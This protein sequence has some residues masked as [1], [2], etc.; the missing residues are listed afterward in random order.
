MVLTVV[1]GFLIYLEGNPFFVMI[2]EGASWPRR[3]HFSLS[4]LLLSMKASYLPQIL[5]AVLTAIEHLHIRISVEVELILVKL[6]ASRVSFVCQIFFHLMK[7]ETS[8]AAPIEVKNVINMTARE[9]PSAGEGN[10]G[11]L[12][13][14]FIFLFSSKDQDRQLQIQVLS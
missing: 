3:L 13:W 6:L 11:T 2:A 1:K 7:D 9:E 14:E 5:S 8:L 10:W 12:Q 4:K